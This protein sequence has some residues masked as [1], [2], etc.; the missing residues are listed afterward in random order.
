[1]KG[2]TVKRALALALAM[3]TSLCGCAMEPQELMDLLNTVRPG[4]SQSTEQQPDA[5]QYPD[6]GGTSTPDGAPSLDSVPAAGP[7]TEEGRQSL[8]WLRERIGF[9]GTMFGVAYLG[10]VDG[11]FE[12][13]F[14]TGFPQWLQETNGV[15]LGKYPFIAEIDTNHIAG[16]AGHLYCI[17]PVDEVA[18]L[19]INRVYWNE[20]TQRE[21]VEEVLYRSE[22][23]APVLLFANLD[24]VPSLAD[25]RVTITDSASNTC[26][27][28]PTLDEQGHIVPCMAEDGIYSSADFT[29]YGW[30]NSPAALNTWL[31]QGYGGMTA[32]GLAGWGP[33]AMSCWLTKVLVGEEGRN[34]EFTLVF[35]PGDK[36]GGT[37]DLYWAY[38]GA[39]SMGGRWGGEWTIETAL[40]TP[41]QVTIS[42]VYANEEQGPSF[43]EAVIYDT[44][45]FLID[46]SGM[47]LV[48]GAGAD[49]IPLPFM[50]SDEE[51]HLLT[52]DE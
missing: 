39:F 26:D 22:A 1:M 9:E 45:P 30:Q 31:V 27:W 3:A 21:E 32:E 20:A 23:G 42:L 15:T 49:G 28:Y 52:R 6:E 13:G 51:V 50:T 4:S 17:V 37:V 19:V 2:K 47:K 12:K 44:Y 14:E 33:D 38:E 41:S 11:L 16:G 29:E 34:V 24:D 5:L 7:G 18:T 25:T 46:P 36:R 40:D 35:Y 43:G 10:Y 8:Q 48:I